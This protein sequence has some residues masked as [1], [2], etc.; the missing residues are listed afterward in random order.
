MFDSANWQLPSMQRVVGGG[1]GLG[2]VKRCY[3]LEVSNPTQNK[4]DGRN[5]LRSPIS[6]LKVAKVHTYTHTRTRIN[7]YY[8][9]IYMYECTC[10]CAST[11]IYTHTQQHITW[12]HI[13]QR[14]LT[15]T[16]VHTQKH[17]PTH[18]CTLLDKLPENDKIITTF[19]L[20]F[21]SG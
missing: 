6:V 17:L 3:C 7:I 8:I 20:T 21:S 2:E 4:E 1:L 5:V 19:K 10:V 13:H 12:S 9:Y 11:C 16:C 14:S 18:T 15:L